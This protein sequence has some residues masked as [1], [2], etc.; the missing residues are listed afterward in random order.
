MAGKRKEMGLGSFPEVSLAQARDRAKE[1]RAKVRD[2]IDPVAERKE[3]RA[4]LE[5]SRKRVKT[6]KEAM[7]ECLPS[8]LVAFKNPKHRDQWQSTLETYAIPEL[9]GMLVHEIT[10]HDVLR[11]LE[12]IWLTKTDTAS[13]LRGRIEAILSWARAKKYTSGENPAAWKGNLKEL[14]PPPGKI[15][16]KE[17][18]PALQIK[19]APRWFAELQRLSGTGSRALE[20]TALTAARSWM[21]RGATWDEIDLEQRIWTIP[22]LR[23]KGDLSK[24]GPGFLDVV[25]CRRAVPHG[26]RSTFK[27]WASDHTSFPNEMSEIALSHQL[28]SK[29]EAAY[30]RGHMVEKRRKMMAAWGAYLVGKS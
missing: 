18:Q 9:G 13:R 24:G 11:V 7:D 3:T 10:V 23:M 27:D 17:H 16:R 6:F 14:L 26:L 1:A 29:V 12:P 20:F 15:S 19:D 8:K 2:G 28:D 5:A 30:R 21:T 22:A 4:V 25:T